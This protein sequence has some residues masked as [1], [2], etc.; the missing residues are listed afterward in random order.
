MNEI[1][2]A[3]PSGTELVSVTTDSEDDSNKGETPRGNLKNTERLESSLFDGDESDAGLKML[4]C[5]SPKSECP[6][7]MDYTSTEQKKSASDLPVDSDYVDNNDSAGEV[8]KDPDISDNDTV[9]QLDVSDTAVKESVKYTNSE[10]PPSDVETVVFKRT[11]SF[12][13]V[14]NNGLLK[15]VDTTETPVMSEDVKKANILKTHSYEVAENGSYDGPGS[16]SE[17]AKEVLKNAVSESKALKDE[18]RSLCDNIAALERMSTGNSETETNDEDSVD[19]GGIIINVDSMTF[20]EQKPTL[21]V[22]GVTTN[23]SATDDVELSTGEIDEEGSIDNADSTKKH[24][25]KRLPVGK[26]YSLDTGTALLSPEDDICAELKNFTNTGSFK[27]QAPVS[28]NGQTSNEEVTTD[29]VQEEN[30]AA[31]P[32]PPPRGVGGRGQRLNYSE[33]FSPGELIRI[34]L[35][36][37]HVVCVVQL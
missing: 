1:L 12:R 28:T 6:V 25:P 35:C 17:E 2:S 3:F 15:I 31:L 10:I 26:R 30:A 11:G 16:D 7:V 34:K 19:S 32:A 33:S 8:Y 29:G 9:A 22:T 36:I 18:F 27:V 21:K 20:S 23:D 13:L 5:F 24:R 14:K 37:A 4:A